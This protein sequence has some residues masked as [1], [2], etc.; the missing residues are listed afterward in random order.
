MRQSQQEKELETRVMISTTKK[1]NCHLCL[2]RPS[3]L[4]HQAK[5][6]KV[7]I[8]KLEQVQIRMGHKTA[9]SS[10]LNQLTEEFLK[11]HRVATVAN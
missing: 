2:N 11:F 6:S 10:Q 3:L 9:L 1:Y 8:I 7:K 5:V 4:A